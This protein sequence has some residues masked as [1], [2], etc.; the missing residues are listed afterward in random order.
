MKSKAM[1]D[2]VAIHLSGLERVW[3]L[4]LPPNIISELP[5]GGKLVVL[6]ESLEKAL[7][8]LKLNYSPHTPESKVLMLSWKKNNS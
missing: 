1:A 5:I 4:D 7:D 6:A 8:L 3:S 2:W